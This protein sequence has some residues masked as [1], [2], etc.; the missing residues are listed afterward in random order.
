ME[1]IHGTAETED[2]PIVNT[3]GE[4]Q[5]LEELRE[6]FVQLNVP[7]GTGLDIKAGQLISLLNYESGDGGAVNANF[8][9]GYQWYYTGNGPSAGVQAGYAFCDKVDLKVR[10]QNGMYAGAIDNNSGEAYMAALGLKP[11]ADLWFSLVGFTSHESAGLDVSGGS[12]LAGFNATK[13]L[14]SARQPAI[15]RVR[16]ST[17]CYCKFFGFNGCKS[18]GRKRPFLRITSPSNFTS[19]PPHSGRWISTMSQCTAERLPLSATS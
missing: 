13:A 11:T 19:P 10:V 2:A 17:R 1:T 16:G 15:I 8:S 18:L 4:N 6:A 5:G 12:L 7:I 9:Q 14:I 3:G